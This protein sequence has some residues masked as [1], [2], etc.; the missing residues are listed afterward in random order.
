MWKCLTYIVLI[1]Q[2]GITY[3]APIT[4]ASGGKTSYRIIVPA[5]ESPFAG[6]AASAL[7]K[8]LQQITGANFEVSND[9]TTPG[10]FE[11]LI[12]ATNRGLHAEG[13]TGMPGTF[14]I[15]TVG[16]KLQ[17]SGLEKGLLYSVYSFLEKYAGCRKFAA[18]QTY[19]P[20]VPNFKIGDI[21]F[22]E[23]PIAKFRGLHYPGPE[24]DQEFLDWHKLQRIDDVWGLWGHTFFKLVPPSKYFDAHPEYYSL[25]NE[26]RIPTQLCLTE[27]AVADITIQSLE[28]A[29]ANDPDKIY[30]SVSQNDGGGQ[31]M[32]ARCTAL[33]NKYGADQGSLLTFVNKIAARFPAKKI[34]TL[35]YGYSR[36]PPV[37]L[38]PSDN[39]VVML[40]PIEV[41]RLRSF[42]VDPRS[43]GFRADLEGW[44]SA[45][46]WLM[47]WDYVAQFTNYQSPFPN[48]NTL[49]PNF[50]YL[51]KTHPEGMFIQGSGE[52]RS[53][54]S[55]LRTYMLAKM[56]SEPGA[57]TRKIE[58]EFVNAYYGPAAKVIHSYLRELQENAS[59]FNVRLDIYDNPVIPYRTY[60]QTV[61]L[62]KY[63]SAIE[64]ALKLVKDNAV[65][66]KRVEQVLLPLQFAL[67]QQ[68]RFYGIENNG[69][70]V[71]AD[72]KWTV[73]PEIKKLLTDFE[74]HAFNT[75]T[76]Q[77][78]EDGLKLESYLAEW[79]QHLAAG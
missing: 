79:R 42:A 49:R 61:D 18:D 69:V 39:V 64:G 66:K 65:M 26:K 31:C 73:R 17:F 74:V 41:S 10:K 44:R 54:F 55:E 28:E 48:I 51:L 36:K 25:V 22:T 60:L 4:L 62:L 13:L 37:G 76:D 38:E 23:S 78:N 57:D 21:N 75:G 9:A 19:V 24:S 71:H 7:K 63:T 12:G 11:I 1:M 47:Y 46:A 16:D 35:A 5:I 59:K 27:P 52:Q 15:R 67:L 43:A 77:L 3:A 14:S 32:C 29:M 56:L 8:Y 50:D 2:A 34:V 68:A 58:T 40:A 6:Q 20:K 45:G 33:N 30:W 72:N 70:F 53:D